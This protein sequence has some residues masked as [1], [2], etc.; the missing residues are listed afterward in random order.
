MS[1]LRIRLHTYARL[2][3]ASLARVAAY[4]LGLK[5]GLHPV[6]RI[7]PPILEPGPI[8]GR[9]VRRTPELEATSAWR[10]GPWAFGRPVGPSGDAPPRWA[11]NILTGRDVANADRR[12]D[13][14]PAFGSGA[15]DIKAV[16][17]ASRFDWVLAFAQ[18][19]ARGEDGALER[20]DA[21]LADWIAGNPPYIGPNWMCGQEAS[22]RV[23]HLAGAAIILGTFEKPS[24][25]LK[26]LLVTHLRRILPTVSYALGQDNNHATSEAAAL[27]VGGAWLEAFGG[28]RVGREARRFMTAGRRLLDQGVRRLVFEDGGFAQYSLVYH[29]VML[30]AVAM[31]EVVRR[32]LG[33]PAFHQETLRKLGLAARWLD[34]MVMEK[35]GDAP[36][37]G[38]NDGA[39]LLPVGPG[40]ARDF[41]PA[42]A[43]SSALFL[44]LGRYTD[45]PE[46]AHQLAWLGVPID[47][48]PKGE[49]PRPTLMKGSGVVLLERGDVRGW[50]RAPRYQYRPGQADALH[51]DLWVGTTPLVIDSG[52][53]S[54]A[55]PDHGGGVHFGSA[56]AHNTV[57]FDDRDQMPR[58]GRFLL[59]AW[60]QAEVSEAEPFGATVAYTDYQGAQHQRRVSLEPDR[61][62]VADT[63]GGFA[64]CA[65]LRWRTDWPVRVADGRVVVSTPDLGDIDFE[66]SVE[67]ET[68]LASVSEGEASIVYHAVKPVS[69][70]SVQIDRPA[71]I[72]TVIRIPSARGIGN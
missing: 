1:S 26:G 24:P 57:Q 11:A 20:L 66:F 29:R 4:R 16:W 44:G 72:E 42:V 38:A 14:I 59:G 31:A 13:R 55:D 52:S 21:W 25:A 54:Y 43:L 47:Q 63:V 41:R 3:V 48:L 69:V 30:D 64:S 65:V 18:R 8:F 62:V 49:R 7:Q 27:F 50:L 17:E 23:L 15:G 33:V 39:W 58:V 5:S 6:H 35:G 56:E 60:V 68:V 40:D 22:I 53:Y 12:W 34:A 70:I 51:L 2:G 9:S 19:A 36:N 71:T 37:L 45:V 10:D 28:A 46:A 32:R 61:V 67:G